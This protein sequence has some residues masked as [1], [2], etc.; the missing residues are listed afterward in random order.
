MHKLIGHAGPVT[1]LDFHPKNVDILASCDTNDVIRLWNVKQCACIHILK[2]SIHAY[3]T[4][5]TTFPNFTFLSIFLLSVTFFKL[6]RGFSQNALHFTSI[7]GLC[8]IPFCWCLETFLLQSA[9]QILTTP[10]KCRM[11]LFKNS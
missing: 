4:H 10:Y 2:V 1:S 3:T 5:S 9:F 6:I 8:L 11:Y 7:P